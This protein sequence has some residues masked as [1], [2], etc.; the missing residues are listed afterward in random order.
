MPDI[1]NDDFNI[2]YETMGP[3]DGLP[4]V[5]VSGSGEQIGSVEFP[6][7]QCEIF[8]RHGFR[9]I[10]MDNR[11]AGLSI[12]RYKIPDL[13]FDTALTQGP[14]AICVPYT[15][16]D[17]AEDI[18]AVLDNLEIEAASLVGA[19]MGGFLVRWC[20]VR[21]PN[22][23]LSLSV[24]MSGSGATADEAGPQWESTV[25]ERLSVL[26]QRYERNE[27]IDRNVDL[28]RWIW[29]NGYPFEEKFVRERVSYAHD[30]AYRPEGFARQALSSMHSPGLWTA[31]SEIECPT[32][33]VHGE[34]DPCFSIEHGRAI[35]SR[36]NGAELWNDIRMGHIMH[37]EQWD[38]LATRIH[39]LVTG[40]SRL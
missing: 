9:V 24:V 11:D 2:H 1:Y 17:M 7:E 30:R 31:Q 29:G 23:V 18:V 26:A 39:R 28:W 20:A 40:T 3:K 4:L 33:V 21:H 13:D 22:R 5:L 37:R 36:I 12:P 15:R 6:I 10:R 16:M 8:V 32:L 19:S 27:A 38:E 34:S 35:Q 14:A 25:L